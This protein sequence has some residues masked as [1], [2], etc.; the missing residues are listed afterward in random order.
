MVPIVVQQQ[1]EQDSS[2]GGFYC[3]MQCDAL[4]PHFARGR[5]C[6]LVNG[7][8]CTT[9]CSLLEDWRTKLFSIGL[10][11]YDCVL[12][13]YWIVYYRGLYYRIGVL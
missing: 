4:R 8:V 6:P 5:H 1:Q 12:V 11:L 7:S 3:L 9:L 13:Y 2:R 10:C